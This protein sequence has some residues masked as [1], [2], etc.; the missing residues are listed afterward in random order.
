MRL[1]CRSEWEVIYGYFVESQISTLLGCCY[2]RSEHVYP[3]LPLEGSKG[4]MS[5]KDIGHGGLSSNS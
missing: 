1:K 2:S 3:F 5:V 4:L